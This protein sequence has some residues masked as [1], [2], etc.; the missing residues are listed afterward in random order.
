MQ[1]S[2]THH[3]QDQEFIAEADG[4]K[5]ELA[6]SLPATGIIDFTHT[7]VDENWRGQGVGE[8]LARRGLDYARQQHLRVRTSC[9]F[10]ERFVQAHQ[11]EY[12]ELLDK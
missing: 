9:E 7:F 3:S 11:Q 8:A 10:M 5:A 2:I 4:R 1:P 6:Y 12:Q